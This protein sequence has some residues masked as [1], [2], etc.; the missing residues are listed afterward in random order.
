MTKDDWFK[1]WEKHLDQYLKAPPRTGIFIH[2]YFNSIKSCLELAC[3]SGRDSIFLAKKNVKVTAS[4]SE[5]RVI[6]DLKKRFIF[7]NLYYHQVDAFC[8]PFNDNSFVLVFHNGFFIYFNDNND[9]CKLLLEQE[10]ISQRYILIVVHNKLNKDLVTNF[11]RLASNDKIY[12]IRFFEPDELINIVHMS[13][14]RINKIRILKFGG[15]FDILYSKWLKRFIPNLFYP[16]RYFIVPKL[17]QYQSW[18]YTERIACI[19]DLKK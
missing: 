3:G 2:N 10:R 7:K 19:I 5:N 4:D 13:G 12:D 1:I 18:E 8:S 6:M 17:Y 16:M 11:S 14:V 15:F 9:L